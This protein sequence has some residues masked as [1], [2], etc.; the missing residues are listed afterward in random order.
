ML[1]DKAGGL[2]DSPPPTI[3]SE[4][5]GEVAAGG[6]PKVDRS[7]RD[8]ILTDL[9]TWNVKTIVVGPMPHVGVMLELFKQVLGRSPQSIEGVSVGWNV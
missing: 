8:E 4:L 7:V 5:M 1:P 2:L 3:T 9:R 6:T